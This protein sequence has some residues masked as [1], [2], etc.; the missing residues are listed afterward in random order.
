MKGKLLVIAEVLLIALVILAGAIAVPILCRPFFYLHIRLLDL[1]ELTGLSVSQIKTVYR[2]MMDYCIGLTDTFSVGVLPFSESGASHFADV[3]KLFILDLQ[4]LAVAAVLLTVLKLCRHKNPVRLAGHT[5]GF[6]SAIGLGVTFLTLG[7]L[8]SLDFNR[9][10][11]VFHKLFFPGKDNWNFSRYADPV[12]DMLPSEFF[13][14]CGILILAVILLSCTA[15]L[16]WDRKD[17]WRE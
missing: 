11:A 3:R 14:N 12:V 7:A 10:F 2:E 13:R 5:P 8:V 6:W 1:P 16:L 4:V 9:A 17:R 15:L